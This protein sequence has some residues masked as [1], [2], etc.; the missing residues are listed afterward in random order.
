[1]SPDAGSYT[2]LTPR[3][4]ERSGV[5][6]FASEQLDDGLILLSSS[7]EDFGWEPGLKLIDRNGE[8]L[9]EWRIDPQEVFP[10]EYA[11]DRQ[12]NQVH[13]SYL[14]ENGDVLV[15]FAYVGTARVSACG[16][17]IWRL[18]RKNHHSIARDDDGTFWVSAR[19]EGEFEYPGLRGKVAENVDQNVLLQISASGQVLREINVLDVLYENA[20]AEPL[21]RQ[22][23]PFLKR[24][25]RGDLISQEL[26]HL[27]DVEP[28]PGPMATEYP[29]FDAGDLL[30]SL[31]HID[32]VFVLDPGTREIKWHASR[33]FIEQHD[34]D[35]SGNGWIGVFD[36]HA[37]G[38]ERGSLLGGSRIV[39]LQ[40]HT[41]SFRTLYSGDEERPFYTSVM[42]KWQKLENGNLL[43]TESEAGRVVEL[44][45]QGRPVWEWVVPP[46]DESRIP[47]VTEGTLY[48][49]SEDRIASWN[50]SNTEHDDG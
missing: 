31:K 30:V 9:H 6:Q 26:T 49:F 23:Q 7:W 45:A 42:G 44:T 37:D 47:E 33:P 21:I 46:Y 50:C 3:V 34:P 25:E 8:L 41:D 13:G 36:N 32:L 14:F 39:S 11:S 12:V 29:L 18:K 4:Y 10:D 43:L 22:Y 15:N 19:E 20:L 1:M 17:V 48:E 40:P 5:A 2:W 27:N 16:E 24:A 38:T 35:F 28:L